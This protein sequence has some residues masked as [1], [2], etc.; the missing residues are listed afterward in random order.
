MFELYAT[1]LY[2]TKDLAKEA[3]R[4]GLVHRKSGNKISKAVM[5]DILNNPMYYGDFYWKGILY[6]GTHQPIISKELFE[7]VQA[8]LNK[9]SSC[10]TGRQ[11]HGFLF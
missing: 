2:S 10:P 11:K 1:G 5:W 8:A 6:N 4:I 7:K 9:R 3:A